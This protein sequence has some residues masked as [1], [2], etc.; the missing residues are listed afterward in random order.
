MRQKPYYKCYEQ[1]R[2]NKKKSTIKTTK[3]ATKTPIPSQI[4]DTTP[5]CGTKIDQYSLETN[6]YGCP[7][8]IHYQHI[9]YTVATRTPNVYALLHIP[10]MCAWLRVCMC[11][12]ELVKCLFLFFIFGTFVLVCDSSG[13]AY[14]CMQWR[15]CEYGCTYYEI[16]V[17]AVVQSKTIH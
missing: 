6:T 5:N 3:M 12:L 17:T 1:T 10:H 14:A 16:V 15:M 4:I 11:R 13:D 7:Y 8:S 2:T 9:T